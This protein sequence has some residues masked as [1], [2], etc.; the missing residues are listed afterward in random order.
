MLGASWISLFERIPAKYHDTLVLTM[1]TGAEIMMKSVLRLE[2]DFAIIRGR[3]AGST[4]AARV[5]VMPYDQIVN[6]AFTKIMLEAE[7]QSVFG[8][9]LQAPTTQPTENSAAAEPTD[10]AEQVEAGE[11]ATAPADSAEGPMR[12]VVTR[13]PGNAGAAAGKSQVQAPSK[14]ILLARLRA[15]LAE[16]GK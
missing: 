9:V 2:E 3:M 15:R 10:P 4:D 1:V 8:S 7:V 11:N 12:T 13:A 14:S 5:I 6:V 16:Q